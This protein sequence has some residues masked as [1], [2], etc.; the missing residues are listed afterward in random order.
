MHRMTGLDAQFLY[1]ERPE[2]PQHTLKLAFLS[3]EASAAFDLARA[4][5]D[6]GA[7]LPRLDPLRWRACRVPLGLHHP[8]WVEDPALDLERHVRRLAIPAPGGHRELCEVVS[9]LASGPLDPVRPLWE[10]WFLEGYE[11]ERVVAVLKLS[12]ALADGCA[13]R[14]LLHRLYAEAPF[15]DAAQASLPALPAE[16]WPSR[17]RLLRDALRDRAREAGVELPRLV[18]A[19]LAARRRLRAARAEGRLPAR[20]E[21]SPLRS[22]RTPFSGPLGRSRA[23]SFATLPL[24][25]VR[26]IRDAVGGTLN[27]VVVATVAGAVRAFLRER[28]GVPDAPTLAHMPASTRSDAERGAWGNRMTAR[29]LPLP[30]HLDDP[31]AQLREVSRATREVK[32]D[33]ELRAGANLEDWLRW[34]PPSA[35]KGLGRVARALFR[36]RPA[37]TVG[38]TVSCVR[39]PASPLYTLGGAVGNFLSVGHVK[40]AA[41]LNVTAWTY[42]DLLNLGLYACADTLRDPERFAGLLAEAFEDLRKA[43]GRE[44][45]RVAP[46]AAAAAGGERWSS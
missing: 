37:T 46:A 12:H 44:A 3:R 16:P 32:L 14:E 8:V 36:L 26:E 6:L 18:R 29:V 31:V 11:G 10:L 13:T 25:H 17:T 45:G 5:R 34:L 27:D 30:T 15:D 20:L 28:G 4:R 24:A 19:T 9:A 21:I 33:L 39:G 42:G 23:F 38:V 40:Y 35:G 2:E 1:D 22:P 41:G 7:R 43:A